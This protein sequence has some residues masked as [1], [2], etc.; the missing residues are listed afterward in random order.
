MLRGNFMQKYT[1]EE[2]K[3]KD[4]K[5]EVVGLAD[6]IDDGVGSLRALIKYIDEGEPDLKVVK[7]EIGE[8]ILR[9]QDEYAK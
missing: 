2:K 8:A 9:L 5:S 4:L 6:L 3:L 1:P 7:S